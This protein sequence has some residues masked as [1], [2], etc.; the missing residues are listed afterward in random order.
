MEIQT[1]LPAIPPTAV[2]AIIGYFLKRSFEGMSRKLDEIGNKVGDHAERI[3]T[4]EAELR[5]LTRRRR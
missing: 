2:L 4:V 5:T 3:A 1:W